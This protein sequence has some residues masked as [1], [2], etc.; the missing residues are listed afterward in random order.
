MNPKA[1][2]ETEKE[3]IWHRRGSFIHF[4]DHLSIT[5]LIHPSVIPSCLPQF[6][7][8]TF[9]STSWD[10]GAVPGSKGTKTNPCI[11]SVHW[12][13]G[14]DKDQKLTR[15]HQW[16]QCSQFLLRREGFHIPDGSEDLEGLCEGHKA[17]ILNSDWL[18]VPSE[19][20]DYW[21][22]LEKREQE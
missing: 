1:Q 20:N 5:S 21:R 3:N 8:Q 7:Q 6:T 9:M 19:Q 2:L 14:S 11:P 22:G 4:E 12:E 16:M 18:Q 17:F 13:G 10:P 15:T